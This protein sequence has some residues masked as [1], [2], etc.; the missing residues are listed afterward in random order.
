MAR[1]PDLAAPSTI[2]GVARRFG[3]QFRRRWGQNFFADRGQLD[4]LV[5]ALAV[6]PTDHIIEIGPGLGVLTRELASRAATV[7]G[8]E[9][10]P[11][12]VRALGLTLRGLP[13]VSI[14]EGDILVQPIAQ[15]SPRPYRVVGNIPYNL[16]GALLGHV[17]ELADTPLQIDLVVQ[18]EVAQRI[19]AA[20][21]DWS[22]ATLGV[23]AYGRADL[24]LTIPKE[25]FF[26]V[27]Q[28]ASALL[29]IVPEP[30]P[31]IPRQDLPAFFQFAR[32]FFQA[33]RKQLPYVLTRRLGLSSAAARELLSQLGIDPSRR[34]ET[35]TL[36]EW[37]RLFTRRIVPA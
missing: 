18:K 20:P 32:P 6:Q 27:P 8:V 36:D 16:T 21:G 2:R 14:I 4:R 31:L 25:A 15:L 5:E 29:R 17:L 7:V 13:N 1:P 30:A 22:L 24:M 19:A 11:A 33:R 9:I 37:R 35:L 10:D 26:P 3:V 23:R 34:P 12:C 28:V